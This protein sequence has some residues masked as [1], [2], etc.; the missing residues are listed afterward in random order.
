[1]LPKLFFSP[2]IQS[3]WSTDSYQ[4]LP[5]TQ[6]LQYC[7]VSSQ[8]ET[9]HCTKGTKITETSFCLP[10][11]ASVKFSLSAWSLFCEVFFICEQP[12][13]WSFAECWLTNWIGW[14]RLSVDLKKV[15]Y[16]ETKTSIY[17]SILLAALMG[18]RFLKENGKR[19]N[20]N[21]N[22][23]ILFKLCTTE[24]KLYIFI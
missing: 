18:V 14:C 2:Q 23:D 20:Q 8:L 21:K 5:H 4:S 22:E 13:L 7:D 12:L 10:A 6:R 16:S 11:S 3:F 9:I 1:M 24:P 17:R 19:L 15:P